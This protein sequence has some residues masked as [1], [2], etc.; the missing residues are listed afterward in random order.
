MPRLLRAALRLSTLV[1]GE[2]TL[3]AAKRPLGPA[4]AAVSN[5]RCL[6]PSRHKD[7]RWLLGKPPPNGGH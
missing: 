4:T 5:V 7:V 3:T 1:A 2:R 6:E